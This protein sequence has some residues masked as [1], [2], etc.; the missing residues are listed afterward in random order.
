MW[1]GSIIALV[2]WSR[3]AEELPVRSQAKIRD[4]LQSGKH[5][6]K[7]DTCRDRF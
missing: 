2:A 6:V 7:V 4:V 5:V 1:T 3:H